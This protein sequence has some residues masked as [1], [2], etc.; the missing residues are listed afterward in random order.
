[1]R[2]PLPRRARAGLALVA[3]L[4]PAGCA[5][6]ASFIDPEADLAFYEQVA[7][8]P[9]ESLAQDRLAGEKVASVFFAEL[10]ARRFATVTDPG[11]VASAAIA[12]RGNT[13]ATAPWSSADLAKLS[14]QVGVQGVF[15]GTVREYDMTQ[16]GREA[17]PVVAF[18]LRFVDAASGRTVWSASETR[19]GGPAFPL[20]GWR[21]ER[22]LGGLTTTMCRAALRSLR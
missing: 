5:G 2:S 1:M 6:P 10:L 4:L 16:V 3:G 18:D 9:F 8:L 20:F 19:R 17:F 14:R 15:L 12:V 7:V 22:T 13:P 21:E 11:A